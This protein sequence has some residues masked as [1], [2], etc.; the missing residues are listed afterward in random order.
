MEGE[1]Q[2]F[3]YIIKRILIMIP[4]L[5][6]VTFIVFTLISMSDVD[7][8]RSKLGPEASQ[9]LVDELNHQYGVDQ[10]FIIRYAKWVWGAVRGDFGDSWYYDHGVAVDIKARFPNTIK[11]TLLSIGIA[12]IIGIPLGVL[13][14]VKQYSWMDRV[15]STASMLLSA[16]PTF[17]MATIG[18]LIFCWRLHW[19]PATG[20]V[21]GWK[22]W[23]L[24]SLTL[25][26]SYSASFLRFTRSAVLDTIRQDYIRTIRSKGVKEKKVIWGHAFRNALLPLITITGMMLGGLLGGAVIMES[27]FVIPGLGTLVMNAINQYDMPMTMAAISMLAGMYMLIMLIVD[28]L[29]AVVDP[30]I[31]AR[32]AAVKKKKTPVRAEEG[33]AAG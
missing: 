23:I 15:F 5:L 9:E 31:R 19:V 12:M 20:V 13:A 1:T 28:I 4:M 32:Y 26:I 14:A 27:V 21:N 6:V 18:V 22:S 25:G 24:P 7:P 8:G 3:K 10:P 29:Y 2:M 30:R 16:V 11:L 17:C 33:G